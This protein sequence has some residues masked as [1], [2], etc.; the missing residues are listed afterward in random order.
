MRDSGELRA[1]LE[2]HTPD[3]IAHRI[4]TPAG[5][6]YLKDRV[7]R[8]I[9]GAITT[10]A[11]VAGVMGAGLPG[12][13]ILILGFANLLADGFSM[14]VSNYLGTRAELQVRRRARAIEERHIELH[15]EGE[16]EEIRE[17]FRQK[18]F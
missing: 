2:E 11:V 1:L 4:R 12:S 18:G 9:E 7:Y 6:S 17:I 15:P 13:V 3:A 14:A 5:Q 8:S 10:F 16:T